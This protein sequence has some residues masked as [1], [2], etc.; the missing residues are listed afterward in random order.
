MRKRGLLAPWFERPALTL[1]FG[2]SAAASVA[3]P[4]LQECFEGSD[5]IA[6]A[7]LSRDGGLPANEFLAR[8]EG[9]FRLVRTFPNDLRWFVHN[10]ADERLLF[11]AAQRVYQ[12]PAT[13]EVHRRLFLEACLD[14]IAP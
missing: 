12:E 13:P 11:R 14:R 1:V 7:A 3:A 5:F 10:E 6:N 8:L 2:L 9:D 4:S